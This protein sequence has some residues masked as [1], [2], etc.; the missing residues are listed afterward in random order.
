MTTEVRLITPDQLSPTFFSRLQKTGPYSQWRYETWLEFTR[1]SAIDNPFRGAA[2]IG[3]GLYEKEK[4]LSYIAFTYLPF[5]LKGRTRV[6]TGCGDFCAFPE[7]QLRDV[8]YFA[9]A[10]IKQ[11]PTSVMV[12]FHASKAT[13]AI[14]QRFGAKVVYGSEQTFSKCIS[15]KNKIIHRLLKPRKSHRKRFHEQSLVIRGLHCQLKSRQAMSPLS[16]S[17][18]RAIERLFER[19]YQDVDI[20]TLRNKA[21]L[22][23]RYLN[24]PFSNNYYFIRIFNNDRLVG[25]AVLQKKNSDARIC[26]FSADPQS[27]CVV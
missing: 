16:P 9:N 26:E 19:D 4:I 7:C 10:Y 13:H 17:E 18:A 12:G 6:V 3:Y 11:K 8:L 23:W 20:A 21:Y 15:R 24:S 5:Y 22:T 1:W 27:R 2:P 14:W 25:F